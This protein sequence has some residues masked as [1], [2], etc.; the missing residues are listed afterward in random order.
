MH[1][2]CSWSGYGRRHPGANP[3]LFL[4]PCR[5][6]EAHGQRP[7]AM[8]WRLDRPMPRTFFQRAKAAAS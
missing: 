1:R 2:R 8:A 6:V 5:L 4:G 7:I 3:Y